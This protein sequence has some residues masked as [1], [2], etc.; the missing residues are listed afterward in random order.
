MARADVIVIVAISLLLFI[1]LSVS[2]LADETT[3]T[4]SGSKSGATFDNDSTSNRLNRWR[5]RGTNIGGHLVLEPWITPSLFYQFLGTYKTWG[6]DAPKHVAF[7]SYSFCEA[8]GPEEANR[9]LRRHWAAWVTE[10]TIREIAATGVNTVRMPVGDWLFVPYQ[11]YIDCF[12]G[13]IEELDRVIHLCKKYNLNVLLDVHALKGSQNSFDNS[14]RAVIEWN[15]ATSFNHIST[16][17][18]LGE[19]NTDTQETGFS[20]CRYSS[21]IRFVYLI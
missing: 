18:W 2:E 4:C 20:F 6:D 11:P 3:F 14:G 5:W 15:S 7:D 21:N 19:Y 12:A 8:L 1:S 10:D 16:A 13:G 9:Q 17:N